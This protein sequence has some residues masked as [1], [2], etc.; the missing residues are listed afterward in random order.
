[1][2]IDRLQ[3]AVLEQFS[4]T[5][6]SPP[7]HYSVPVTVRLPLAV[8]ESYQ[9]LAHHLGYSDRSS[10]IREVLATSLDDLSQFAAELLESDPDQLDLFTQQLAEIDA[11]DSGIL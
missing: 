1:M 2:P 7:V 6:G 8:V 10:L 3:E 4:A 11:D 9:V 5:G